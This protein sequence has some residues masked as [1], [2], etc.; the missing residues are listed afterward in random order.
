MNENL[1]FFISEV[2]S[3]ILFGFLDYFVGVLG[4]NF[5]DIFSFVFE[6]RCGWYVLGFFIGLFYI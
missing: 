1:F 2:F 4:D 3:D 6:I 5:G